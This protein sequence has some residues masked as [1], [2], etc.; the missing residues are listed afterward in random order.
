MTSSCRPSVLTFEDRLC[1]LISPFFSGGLN[2]S[3]YV[4]KF[5]TKDYVSL[6]T[7]TDTPCLP[8][9]PL[10]YQFK[11]YWKKTLPSSVF[12]RLNIVKVTK[13]LST[14]M[15]ISEPYITGI[16]DIIFRVNYWL[17]ILYKRLKVVTG[18][19]KG[20]RVQTKTKNYDQLLD[21]RFIG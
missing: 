4:V 8:R 15:L 10:L 5:I 3:F 20:R 14:Q 17:Y 18:R 7:I 21:Q 11:S 12:F 16:H 9:K 19:D 6:I 13:E 2:Y 1:S